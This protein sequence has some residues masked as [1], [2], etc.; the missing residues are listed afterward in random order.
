MIVL[1]VSLH[2]EAAIM[3]PE[4]RTALEI[5]DSEDPLP[6]IIKLR[7]AM[8][9]RP[10]Q[11]NSR[12]RRSQF[13]KRLRKHAELTQGTLVA[14]LKSRGAKH[15]IPLWLIN[16]IAVTVRGEVI[17]E[18]AHHPDIITI[19]LDKTL[20]LPE[21]EPAGAKESEWSL[22]A[23]RAPELWGLGYTGE[24][25]VVA[26]MDTGVDLDHPDLTD[27]WRGG[28]NS[29]FD[30]H[31]EHEMPYDAHGHG[32]QTMGIMVGG[33]AGGT[34]IGVA[35]GAQWISTKIFDDADETSLSSIHQG[36]QWLLDPDNNPDSDDAPDVINNSWGLDE[37]VNECIDE[38]REDIQTLK[39]AGIAVMFS[40]GNEGPSPSTSISPANYPE[41]FAVGAVD[42]SFAIPV[43][44][45]RGPSVCDGSIYPVV[46]APGKNVRTSDLTFGGLFPDSYVNVTGTSFAAPF[47]TGAMAL[48]LSAN[49]FMSI[50]ELES[51]MKD[52]AKD[53][54]SPG[55]ENEF[56]YGL[57]DIMAAYNSITPVTITSTSSIT[58]TS[59]QIMPCLLEEIYGTSSGETELLRYVRD[60][61][62]AKTHAGRE[63]IN[64]YY[65]WSP[66]IV[67]GMEKDEEF[68]AEVKE[69]VDG[70]LPLIM[71]EVE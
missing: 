66:A 34:S 44:S 38:F 2:S 26:S 52:S 36:F 55:P 13:I 8:A 45:S 23:I 28:T 27:K 20:K 57:I 69:M 50:S 1:L 70:L 71:G 9:L 35:P 5:I 25:I 59:I 14:F 12:Q 19:R 43:F 64:L 67:E 39:A 62:L 40:A 49:P 7:H 68:K 37:N 3:N 21:G 41:S 58:T 63:I 31:G 60:T 54:G 56:G 29:W 24:G 42:D 65:E 53:L 17:R 46:V 4:L 18:L 32:T 48:L 61:V 16:G 47:V 6:V 51:A 30:P 11:Q 22:D 15:I 33:S 10:S